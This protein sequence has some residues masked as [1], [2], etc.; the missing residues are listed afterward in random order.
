LAALPAVEWDHL[1]S[2]FEIRL[3][4]R[5]LQ[6][7]EDAVGALYRVSRTLPYSEKIEDRAGMAATKVANH[8]VL[9]AY[10][11]HTT[12]DGQCFLVE[13]NTNASGYLLTALMQEAHGRTE[14]SQKILQ[15]LKESFIHELKLAGKPFS[16]PHVAISDENIPEQK[17]LVEFLMYQDW[18]KSFGWSA[19]LCEVKDLRLHNG[20][21][22]AP[23]DNYV[24]FV[25]NRSTDFY[26][27]DSTH[28]AL[29]EAFVNG[30]ACVSP[31]PREYWL[32]ADKQRLIEYSQPN[33]WAEVGA[34]AEDQARIQA[35]LLPTFDR[36]SF[37]SG[38]DI[39]NQR[40]TLFFKPKRSHGGK[41]VYRG[42]SVS[43]KVFERLMQEDVL[44]QR[45]QPA[46]KVP[47]DDDRSVLSTWKFDLRVYAYEDQVQQI[48]ARIY[49]GQVTNFASKLGGFT[50]V[51]PT[52]N[53]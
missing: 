12:E 18:F 37:T 11:F 53:P 51:Q 33:F 3:P 35:V 48:A 40:K 22:A 29:R 34:S 30:A 23:V 43:R 50:M 49:Q 1:I 8:S 38:D 5:L 21:L 45:F 16:T 46:Q 9:M 17:M 27:E 4:Q 20:R 7:A 42:E 47:T 26:F 24:D 44:I 41:S 28:Q 2:P 6:A 10:D 14:T 52:K 19:E 25:Y 31:N 15:S 36:G 39:W 13:V 32:L